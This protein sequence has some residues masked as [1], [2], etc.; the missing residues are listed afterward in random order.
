MTS[1]FVGNDFS[2]DLP[3]KI[4]GNS[5]SEDIAYKSS[6]QLGAVH[7]LGVVRSLYISI[8]KMPTESRDK[9]MS[10]LFIGKKYSFGRQLLLRWNYPQF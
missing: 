8:G 3:T 9:F 5:F 2:K 4:A 6:R 10:L 7:I 1:K